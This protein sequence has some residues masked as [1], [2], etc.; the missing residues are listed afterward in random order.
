[1]LTELACP[2]CMHPIDIRG[3]GQ[4]VTCSACN[5]QFI[6]TGHLCPNCNAYH[7][8]EQ[9]FCSECGEAISRVCLKCQTM[10]WVGDEYCK[11]CGAGMDIFDLLQKSYAQTTADRLN[12][13]MAGAQQIKAQE[14][15]ASEL[16]MSKMMADEQRRLKE[17]ARHRAALRLKDQQ[18]F[19]VVGLVLL[20][21]ILI[22]I[23]ISF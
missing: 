16:R 19:L 7:Q 22:A 21:V 2:N 3:H 13:Q 10:N 14:Q 23:L 8:K 15:K 18:L 12:E 1:M 17:L 20:F 4:H 11:Q 5:S 9:P 6:L